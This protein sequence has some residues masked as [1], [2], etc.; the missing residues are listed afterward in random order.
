MT[1]VAAELLNLLGATIGILSE[2]RL[3]TF[4]SKMLASLSQ[5]LRHTGH[6]LGDVVLPHIEPR[7]HLLGGLIHHRG[8][9]T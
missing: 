4:F 8:A 1:K 3:I 2:R 7:G 9:P 5:G 6:R